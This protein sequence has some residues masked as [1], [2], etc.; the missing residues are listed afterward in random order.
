MC[1]YA[2]DSN[3]NLLYED[4]KYDE[5]AYDH[6]YT[7]DENGNR[8]ENKTYSNSTGYMVYFYKYEY[9]A[10]GNCIKTVEYDRDGNIS[11]VM[12]DKYDEEGRPIECINVNYEYDS[13]CYRRTHEYI[14]VN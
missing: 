9:D 7:Y 10:N 13:A 2:Y 11:S 3:G 14:E 5:F 6:V 8:I 4:E 1:E 12:T